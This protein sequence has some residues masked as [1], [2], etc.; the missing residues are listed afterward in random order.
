MFGFLLVFGAFFLTIKIR[1]FGYKY[2][3]ASTEEKNAAYYSGD[4]PLIDGFDDL[5]DRTTVLA[6]R[7]NPEDSIVF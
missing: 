4:H 2:A 7:N 3:P 5:Y 1:E 6:D